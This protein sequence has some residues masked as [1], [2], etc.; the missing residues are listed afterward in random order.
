MRFSAT[1]S[2]CTVSDVPNRQATEATCAK[3]DPSTVTRVP[4]SSDPT[5]GTT[6][7]RAISPANAI[8]VNTRWIRRSSFPGPHT[9]GAGGGTMV[10]KVERK[11][12]NGL[13]IQCELQLLQAHPSRRRSTADRAV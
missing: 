9:G 10:E 4:P 3:L 12:A 2:P 6:L 13:G 1:N 8:T 5:E 11:A 7:I